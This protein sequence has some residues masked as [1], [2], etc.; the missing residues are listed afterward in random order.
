MA[1]LGCNELIMVSYYIMVFHQHQASASLILYWHH[2]SVYKRLIMHNKPIIKSYYIL[3]G[4]KTPHVLSWHI[5]CRVS[6]TNSSPPS[7]TYMHQWIRSA[8]VQIM[9]CR[10]FG[11]KPLSKPVLGYYQNTKLFIHENA[12]EN[13]ICKMAAILSKADEYFRWKRNKLLQDHIVL[14]HIQ[15]MLPASVLFLVWYWPVLVCR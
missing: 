4:I 7:V 10:L 3:H 13:I 14:N 11:T 9:A 12:P 2:W 6:L 5:S 15:T 1:S 8:L